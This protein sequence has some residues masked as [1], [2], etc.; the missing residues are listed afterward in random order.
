MPTVPKTVTVP[1]DSELGLMLKA[2][3]ASGEPIVVDT[4]EGRY[5]L[6]VALAEPSRDVFAGYDPQAAIAGLRALDDALAGVDR[7]E[8]LTDLRAQRAQDSVGRPA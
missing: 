4:G 5:T 8:L 1:P 3:Q 2:A 7:E 6:V